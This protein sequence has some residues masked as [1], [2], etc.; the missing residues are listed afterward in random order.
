MQTIADPH[1]SN[2]NARADFQGPSPGP[3]RT[4]H[5][6]LASKATR[7]PTFRFAF[8]GV[9]D[10]RAKFK[11]A[12]RFCFS[13]HDLHGSGVT[14]DERRRTRAK[15]HEE[16]EKCGLTSRAFGRLTLILLLRFVLSPL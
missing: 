10:V 7:C 16:G 8:A 1:N 12:L 9:W 13:P 15:F 4:F 11:T 5:T 3:T 14:P 6:L 2:F